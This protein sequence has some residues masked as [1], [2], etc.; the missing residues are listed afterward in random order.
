MAGHRVLIV[1]GL[2]ALGLVTA[3]CVSITGDG[4][5]GTRTAPP[6]ETRPPDGAVRVAPTLTA[7]PTAGGD[8]LGYISLDER[9][10]FARAVTRSVVAEAEAAGVELIACDA[11]LTIEGARGCAE[12]LAEAGIVGLISFVGTPAVADEVCATV[13]GVPT[14]GVAFPQGEC[15]VAIV[16]LDQAGSGRLVGDAVGRWVADEWDCRFDAYVS[17]EDSDAGADAIA[18]MRGMREGFEAHCPIRRRALE[19]LDGAGRVATARARMERTLRDRRGDRIVV[20]GLND[21]AVTGARAAATAAGRADDVIY[22]GQGAD[23]S[24]RLDIACDPRYIASAAHFPERYGAILVPTL[25]AALDGE[26]VDRTIDGPLELV[27]ATTIREHYPDT[28]DCDV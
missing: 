12:R 18:R 8:R 2:L 19:T 5:A 16:R 9:V 21:D 17:L 20:V 14:I 15:E 3:G 6:K 25:L 26:A 23:P 28:P 1:A 22:G 11:G 24:A 7:D 4:E 10:P 13:G 27:D